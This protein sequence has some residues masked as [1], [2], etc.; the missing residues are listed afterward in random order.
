MLPGRPGYMSRPPIFRPQRAE[1]NQKPQ[2]H[3]L[4]SLWLNFSSLWPC[5]RLID[6]LLASLEILDLQFS[7]ERMSFCIEDF[8]GDG[9]AMVSWNTI[10]G[11]GLGI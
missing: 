9:E 4:S 7:C 3:R 2:L 11:I 10:D 1:N 5:K 8:L 6:F